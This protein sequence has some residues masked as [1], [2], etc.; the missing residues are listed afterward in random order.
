MSSN[1]RDLLKGADEA[2]IYND[3]AKAIQSYL[4]V[5]DLDPDNHHA[6]NQLK[7]VEMLQNAD[8]AY[9]ATEYDEAIQ[10]Y[11]EV[12]VLESSNQHA[13]EQLEK[14]E[15]YKIPGKSSLNLPREA[16]Q[17]YKRSRSFIS[18]GDLEQAR[19]FL[20]QAISIAKDDGIDFQ[21]AKML[22]GNLESAQKAEEFKKLA[23][24]ALDAQH[25]AKSLDHLNSA[26]VFDPTDDTVQSLVSHLQS[27]LKA[28][29]LVKELDAGFLGARKRSKTIKDIRKII[30]ATNEITALNPLWQE[31]VRTLGN[32]RKDLIPRGLLGVV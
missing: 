20:Q 11:Y 4:K 23:F 5:L 3:Y 24:E 1:L 10:L 26:S 21:E 25:W 6:R 7:K 12:L 32:Y 16:I 30:E 14:A 17:L 13:R 28:Q 8:D 9:Y 18:A 19:Q 22:L 27:L 2:Y 31:V 29:N 15:R